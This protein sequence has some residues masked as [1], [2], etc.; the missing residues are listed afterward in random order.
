MA[1]KPSGLGRGLEDLLADNAPE[2][3]RGTGSVVKKDGEV[4][5]PMAA[6]APIT[7]SKNGLYEIKTKGLYEDLPRIRT[8][9]TNGKYGK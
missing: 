4:A 8:P 7:P 9:K 5:T 6:P 3:R 2:L 1:K